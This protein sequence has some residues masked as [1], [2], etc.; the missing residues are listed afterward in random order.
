M[1]FHQLEYPQN[2]KPIVAIKKWVRIPMFS[3]YLKSLD[4]SRKSFKTSS[5]FLHANESV[6]VNPSKN[7]PTFRSQ[8][9]VIQVLGCFSYVNSTLAL[10]SNCAYSSAH[11]LQTSV[12]VF[13]DISW[14]VHAWHTSLW[15]QKLNHGKFGIGIELPTFPM[16][17]GLFYQIG[18]HNKLASENFMCWKTLHFGYSLSG[19]CNLIIK[20]ASLKNEPWHISAD[21]KT[22]I[23]RYC[24]NL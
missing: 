14:L 10:S 6:S 2:T 13:L 15:S 9:R 17:T 4:D 7:W 8:T 12:F 21:P 3:R 1:S 18:R 5:W 16:T 23:V 20:A 22:A 19:G 11:A 24:P